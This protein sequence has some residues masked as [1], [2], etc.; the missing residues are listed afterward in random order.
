MERLTRVTM[1]LATLLVALVALS[2]LVDQVKDWDSDID[3]AEGAANRYCEMV[4]TGQWPDYQDN[5]NKFCFKDKWN[6]K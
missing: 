2:M 1:F 4:Y 3:G 6:G 5:Y